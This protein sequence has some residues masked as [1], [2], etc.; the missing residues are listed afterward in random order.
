MDDLNGKAAQIADSA[1]V[2]SE[3]RA[4]VRRD[5]GDRLVCAVFI[6]VSCVGMLYLAEL[7]AACAGLE[8]FHAR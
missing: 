4:S 2:A 3:A 7:V 5:A 1:A 6:V 8:L